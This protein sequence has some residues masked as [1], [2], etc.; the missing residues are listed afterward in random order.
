MPFMIVTVIGVIASCIQVIG[1]LE[2]SPAL[3]INIISVVIKVYS[4]LCVNSLY[5]M[6]RNEIKVLPQIFITQPLFD[7]PDSFRSN[8]LFM[9]Q[10]DYI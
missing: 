7:N 8:R 9:L 1:S 2:L 6:F 5:D 3:S 10:Q 4:F